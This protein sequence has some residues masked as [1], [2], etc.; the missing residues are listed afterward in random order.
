MSEIKVHLTVIASDGLQ[1]LKY[2]ILKI[3]NL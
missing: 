2:L 1:E 3:I